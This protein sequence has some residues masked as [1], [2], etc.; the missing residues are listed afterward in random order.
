M[1]RAQGGTNDE[2]ANVETGHD[3]ERERYREL[4]EELRTLLPGVQVLF[5]FLLIAPFSARFEQLDPVGR[6]GHAIA[7]VS[8]ALATVLFLAPTSYHRVAPLQDR[9]RRMRLGVRLTVAGMAAVAVS[10]AASVFV[11]SRFV[12][13]NVPAATLAGGLATVIGLVWYVL[14]LRRRFRGL[15]GDEE[16]ASDKDGP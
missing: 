1:R 12:Y 8:A 14:P 7:M 11:V 10:I 5:A 15:A 3:A 9:D 4:L 16:A 6:D 13:G 2:K